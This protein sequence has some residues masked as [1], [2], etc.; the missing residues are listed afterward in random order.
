MEE[1]KEDDLPIDTPVMVKIGDEWCLEY[2][3]GKCNFYCN[4]K[5]SYNGGAWQRSRYIV[6][7]DKFNPN[8]IKES[9][10]HNIVK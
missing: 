8:N 10:K 5:K 9:L 4:S 7:F 6:P 2:Y 3:A 1:K